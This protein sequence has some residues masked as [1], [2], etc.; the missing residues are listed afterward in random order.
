[1]SATVLFA[2]SSPVDAAS[3]VDFLTWYREVH[4]PEMR[5]AIPEITGATCYR[6]WD[7]DAGAGPSRFVTVYEAATED[8]GALAAAL[9]GA[10]SGFTISSAMDR[11]ENVPMMQFGGR[12]D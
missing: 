10:S 5:E 7:P 11:S 2:Y 4:I 1:M 12:V 6:L 3:E 8:P 9:S